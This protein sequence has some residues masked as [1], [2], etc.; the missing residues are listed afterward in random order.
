MPKCWSLALV[1]LATPVAGC[2]GAEPATAPREDRPAAAEQVSSLLVV[3]GDHVDGDGSRSTAEPATDDAS[4]APR[5]VRD[6]LAS[7]VPPDPWPAPPLLADGTIDD[8][9]DPFLAQV[10]E[11]Q[12]TPVEDDPSTTRDIH[13]WRTRLREVELLEWE[14]LTRGR[15]RPSPWQQGADTNMPSVMRVSVERCGGARTVATGVVLDD[16]TVVT[17]A[18]VVES[19]ARRVR[20]SPAVGD[21]P[22]IPAMV[23]YLDVDDDIAVLKVPGLEAAPLPLRA[24]A[25]GDPQWAYTYGVSR[26]AMAGSLR[27]APAVVAMEETTIAI[28][29]PDGFARQIAERSVFPMV[30]PLTSGFS[31]GVVAVSSDGSLDGDWSFHG[32]VRARV[33]L[34]SHT[35]GI[36]VPARLVREAIDASRGLPP[37]FEHRPGGCPQWHR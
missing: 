8:G 6:A 37:W 32:L 20:I 23:R 24:P 26:G 19:A 1:L 7:A 33:P 5:R 27:R 2:G 3:D 29:Q 9:V 18:H 31:G 36:V 17:T 25:A 16:E 34:R 22:R 14:R 11:S 13:E 28:E 35:A 10:L 30:A 21:E 4:R 12:S 15:S